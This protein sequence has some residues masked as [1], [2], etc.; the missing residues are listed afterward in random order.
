[1]Y[2]HSNPAHL[3]FGRTADSSLLKKSRGY[4]QGGPVDDDEDPVHEEDWGKQY[5]ATE[6]E[7]HPERGKA[8]WDV[9]RSKKVYGENEF[10]FPSKTPVYHPHD[11]TEEK[12][13]E[14]NKEWESET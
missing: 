6:V 8:P 1:M 7:K 4:Q 11:V 12:E 13:K 2:K 9:K 14:M 5:G 3:E 10:E